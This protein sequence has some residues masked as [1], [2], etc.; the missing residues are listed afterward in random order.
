[1]LSLLWPLI[2][3]KMPLCFSALQ[4]LVPLQ[5]PSSL[6]LRFQVSKVEEE[7][8]LRCMRMVWHLNAWKLYVQVGLLRLH[9]DTQV[10]APM[11]TGQRR[12]R[13]AFCTFHT[14]PTLISEQTKSTVA[15]YCE[16][17][18][19]VQDSELSYEPQTPST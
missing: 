7:K 6:V 18:A 9:R 17:H 1:M 8:S 16:K 10:V 19:D 13:R 14:T 3:D 5:V 4:I 15:S 11:H 12:T 2:R